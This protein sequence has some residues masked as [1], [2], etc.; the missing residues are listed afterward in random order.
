MVRNAMLA[1]CLGVSVL[2]LAGWM[3]AAQDDTAL[4]VDPGALTN[5]GVEAVDVVEGEAPQAPPVTPEPPPPPAE[6]A[7]P[8]A[9]PEMPAP[10]EEE[11]FVEPE[12]S[13]EPVA[14][15]PPSARPRPTRPT[16]AAR[17]IRVNPPRPATPGARPPSVPGSPA[18]PGAA[19]GQVSMPA[20]AP[21]AE[22]PFNF[23]NV[24]LS[25]VIK[26]IGAYTKKNFDIDPNIGSTPVTVITYDKIPPEMAYEVLESILTSRGFSMVETIDGNLVKILPTAEA[27]PSDKTDLRRGTEEIPKS[28]DEISTRIVT[29]KYADATELSTILQRLG[30]KNARID[31]YAPTQALIITD[32]ADGLRRMFSF[33]EEVD[34]P[35]FETS[36]EIFT[37]EYTRAEVIQQQLEQ[38]LM[39]TGATGPRGATPQQMAASAQA[40]VRPTR[41][42]RP[43]VPGAASSTIVGAREET[44]RMVPDERLNALIVVATDGMLERVRDLV[45]RLDTPTPYEANNLHIYELLHADAEQVETALQGIVGT[46]PRAGSG[47]GGGGP[48]G[49]PGGG[50]GGGAAQA[51]SSEVQPFEQ[52]VQV[53]RYDQTNSLLVVSSPQDYK[54]LEAFIARLDVPARQ[55]HVDAVIMDVTTSNDFGLTVDTASITGQDAFGLTNT[56]NISTIYAALAG[57]ADTANDIVL[58]PE[59]GFAAGAALLGLGSEGGLTTGIFDQLTFEYNGQKISVP[60]V[61]L[62]FQAIEKLTDVEVLSQPSLLTVDNEEAAI[63]VGQE[64]PFVVGTSQPSTN[65]EG[66][67]ISTGYTRVQREEVGVKLT[68]TPQISEGDYVALQLEIEVSDL[69]AKQVGT[70]DI[71]GPTT[72]KSLVT[73]RV[74]VKDGSTAV[75][76]GLIRD[77]RSRDVTQAPILGDIPVL[78]WLFTSRSNSQNKRNMVV[79]V[80]P[81]IAKEGVDVSRI[82]QYK[83]GEYRDANIDALFEKGFFKKIKRKTEMRKG[84]HPTAEQTDA[85]LG[86]AVGTGFGRGDIKR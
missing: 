37:L 84:H 58:G 47:G 69:D 80:T 9:T 68:V 48:G 74:V 49:A 64:V 15:P 27:V 76:A 34:V 81:H 20:D 46:A 11:P 86:G 4:D 23:E 78:G 3:A 19:A 56:A 59:S 17:P 29:V 7:P 14:P 53:T 66:N 41:T 26:M 57:T 85:I 71:L 25:Q 43:T 44:L 54:L 70:V 73:N 6:V 72:N 1:R 79:L 36:M 42:V 75:I 13:P 22:G 12:P 30:S 39:E 24:E 21:K 52:K 65:T 83:V 50:G 55:V 16:P 51:V 28:F 40:P 18:G 33:L 38:V 67:L 62:L 32:S 63:V 8:P 45:R 77:N 60:F 82:T 31:V 10:A 35:G 2:V 61:P 5:A